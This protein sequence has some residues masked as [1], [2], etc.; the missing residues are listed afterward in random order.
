MTQVTVL[1]NEWAW[2]LRVPVAE[3]EPVPMEL[4]FLWHANTLLPFI[5]SA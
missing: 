4:W 5:G 1:A 3:G 2:L